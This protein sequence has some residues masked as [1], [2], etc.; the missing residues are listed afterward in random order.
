M[1]VNYL[2]IIE[3]LVRTTESLMNSLGMDEETLFEEYGVDLQEVKSIYQ[4]G[5]R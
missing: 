3:D 1:A 2:S 4:K 5:E